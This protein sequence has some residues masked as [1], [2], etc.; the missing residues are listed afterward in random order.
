MTP[1][2]AA[3]PKPVRAGAAAR[4]VEW[5]RVHWVW[6][7]VGVAVI[8]GLVVGIVLLTQGGSGGSGGG[9]TNGGSAVPGG[10]VGGGIGHS[11]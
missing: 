11:P 7:V 2:A 4:A 10:G 8:A 9:G 6:C 5:A 1:P 3:A